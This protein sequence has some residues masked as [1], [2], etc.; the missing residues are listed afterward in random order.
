MGACESKK[1]SNELLNDSGVQSDDK[2]KK[3]VTN[4]D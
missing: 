1:A 2:D 3:A 4:I